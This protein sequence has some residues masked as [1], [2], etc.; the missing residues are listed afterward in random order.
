MKKVRTFSACVKSREKVKHGKA[1][2]EDSQ[3]AYCR[4]QLK[5]F[6]KSTAKPNKTRFSAEHFAFCARFVHRSSVCFD[7]YHRNFIVTSRIERC[8]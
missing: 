1:R 6:R 4:F 2:F 8:N 7:S 3:Q 5:V